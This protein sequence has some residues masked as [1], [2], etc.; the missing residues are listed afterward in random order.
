MNC[1]IICFFVL[2]LIVLKVYDFKDR[3]DIL[4]KE[5][6]FKD[7]PFFTIDLLESIDVQGSFNEETIPVDI[8]DNK[9][10]PNEFFD[11]EG[12]NLTNRFHKNKTFRHFTSYLTI[13]FN[14]E[15]E[16]YQFNMEL[17]LHE[18]NVR[19]AFYKQ[20]T[21]KIFITNTL[22]SSVDIKDEIIHPEW[23]FLDL[24]FL[25]EETVGYVQLGEK[26]II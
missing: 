3:K 10:N 22:V 11:L 18:I 25:E 19:M 16:K 14:Y 5:N 13:K 2:V 9:I 24:R 4:E 26:I 12:Y 8:Y 15:G 17:P 20:G 6:F 1:I 7:K 23:F 21:S